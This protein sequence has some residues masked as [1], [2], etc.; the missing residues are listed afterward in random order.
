MQSR[1]D[2]QKTS[3]LVAELKEFVRL[4]DNGRLVALGPERTDD[5]R[6][7]AGP[8]SR[9]TGTSPTGR[10]IRYRIAAEVVDVLPNGNV[11]LEA[12][13]SIRSNRDVWEIHPHRHPLE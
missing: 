13:K 7:R 4:D 2:R 9:R 10:G 8:A 1:F 3:S 5:R 11:V 6:R 12:R